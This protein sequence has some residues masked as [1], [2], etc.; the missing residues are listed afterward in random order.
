MA[1]MAVAIREDSAKKIVQWMVHPG[2]IIPT[3]VAGPKMR[4]PVFSLAFFKSFHHP[5]P[6][7][8]INFYLRLFILSIPH[9]QI[10]IGRI[11]TCLFLLS[12]LLPPN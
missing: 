1:K 4:I 11:L 3:K 2:I 10:L 7:L 9:F 12:H 5:I 6:F 8:I